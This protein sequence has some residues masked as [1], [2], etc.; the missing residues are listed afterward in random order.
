MIKT[1]DNISG[2][3]LVDKPEG[4][5][6]H[7]VVDFIRH[8]FHIRKVGHCGTL[9]PIGTGVLVLVLGDTTR[10][11][12]RYVNDDKTYQFTMTLGA[13]TDTQDS[14]GKIIREG[15]PEGINRERV[16]S[17]IKEFKGEIEQIPPMVSAKHHKGTRLYKLARKGIEVEREPKKVY[18]HSLKIVRLQIPEVELIVKSSK[19]TYIRTLCHDIGEKLGCGAHMSALRRLVS[20]DFKIENA[21]TKDEL[22]KMRLSDLKQIVRNP[23]D[24][25]SP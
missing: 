4:V 12:R 20:G 6:S 8:H 2:V 22:I 11:S 7:D 3:L 18:I 21:C 13:S 25:P 5:T 23:V 9:D 16:E 24:G 15:G 14:T 10:L 17:V 1:K 19:G